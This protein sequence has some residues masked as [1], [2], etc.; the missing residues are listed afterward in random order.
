M[1]HPDLDVWIFFHAEE[2]CG[3]AMG[4]HDYKEL[5]SDVKE[6]KE[7]VH[8]QSKELQVVEVRLSCAPWGGGYFLL[9]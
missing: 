4:E 9:T 7:K 6:L 1:R 3:D 5:N 8:D 2:T